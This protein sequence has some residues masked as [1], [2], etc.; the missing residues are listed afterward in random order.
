MSRPSPNSVQSA[1][2]QRGVLPIASRT[3]NSVALTSTEAEYVAIADG[4]K[5][6]YLSGPRCEVRLIHEDEAGADHLACNRAT[7]F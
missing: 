5:E 2:G 3:Q 1:G 6:A 4:M 7:T